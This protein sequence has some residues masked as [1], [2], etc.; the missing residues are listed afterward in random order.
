MRTAG[1]EIPGGESIVRLV[2]GEVIEALNEMLQ[3]DQYVCGGAAE[4]SVP[5]TN[6]RTAGSGAGTWLKF[7]LPG[8][9]KSQ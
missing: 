3:S 5:E 4:N 2:E 6:A 1:A 8:K 9:G 7:H